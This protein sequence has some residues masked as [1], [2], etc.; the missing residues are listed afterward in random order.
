M[1]LCKRHSPAGVPENNN[2]YSQYSQWSIC[3][4]A[5]KYAK[6]IA[7]DC[8]TMRGRLRSRLDGSRPEA[9]E[10]IVGSRRR[11]RARSVWSAGACSPFRARRTAQKRPWRLAR[12]TPEAS[13][14]LHPQ[15]HSLPPRKLNLVQ[16]FTPERGADLRSAVRRA[17]GPELRL[18]HANNTRQNRPARAKVRNSAEKCGKK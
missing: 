10:R 2:Q 1:G 14:R 11:T 6:T 7:Y 12:R 8:D 9:A 5:P 17:S 3:T 15:P 18:P 16:L 4:G 13:P